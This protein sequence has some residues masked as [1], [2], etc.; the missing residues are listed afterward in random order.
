MPRKLKPIPPTPTEISQEQVTPYP[1]ANV[2]K[3]EG[4]NELNR[5]NQISLKGDNTTKDV[6]IGLQD[7]DEAIMYYFDNVIK[8]TVIQNNNHHAHYIP[9]FLTHE[10]H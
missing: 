1:P 8:P 5:G 10:G 2:E 4:Q 9:T 6:S 7:I 3:Q